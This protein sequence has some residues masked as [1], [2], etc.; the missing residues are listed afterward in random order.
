MLQL[1]HLSKGYGFR[2]QGQRARDAA[3][4]AGVIS[5]LELAR[6]SKSKY[7]VPTTGDTEA[8]IED[9]SDLAVGAEGGS[10]VGLLRANDHAR[11]GRATLSDNPLATI[12]ARKLSLSHQAEMRPFIEEL[13]RH[14]GQFGIRVARDSD[15][16]PCRSTLDWTDIA[17]RRVQPTIRAILRNRRSGGLGPVYQLQSPGLA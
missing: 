9:A 6:Y 1:N 14:D 10:G 12:L 17:Q 11:E 13:A 16:A 4:K 7:Y 2:G 3:V 8:N 15:R 5:P